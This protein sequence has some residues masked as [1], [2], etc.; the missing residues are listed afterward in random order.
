MQH[1]QYTNHEYVIYVVF[2][3]FVTTKGY[4]LS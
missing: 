3:K 2:R 1:N 4:F